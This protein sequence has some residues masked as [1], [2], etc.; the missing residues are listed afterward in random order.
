MDLL[1]IKYSHS[2]TPPAIL[3]ALWCLCCQQI[4][5][6]TRSCHNICRR[7]FPSLGLVTCHAKCHVLWRL[8]HAGRPRVR[9]G[10]APS[11]SEVSDLI[12]SPLLCCDRLYFLS[13]CLDTNYGNKHSPSLGAHKTLCHV[14]RVSPQQFS[15]LNQSE[16]MSENQRK[17]AIK[18]SYEELWSPLCPGHDIRA[19]AGSRWWGL[20]VNTVITTSHRGVTHSD[21]KHTASGERGERGE[22]T[23]GDITISIVCRPGIQGLQRRLWQA[24]PVR[25]YS[26]YAAF[27]SAAVTRGVTWQPCEQSGKGN[28]ILIL[29]SFLQNKSSLP[30][31]LNET[32]HS[33]FVFCQVISL[34]KTG[35]QSGWTIPDLS[36]LERNKS[37]TLLY[38]T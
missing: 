33:L 8:C 26:D 21:H 12:M 5:D 11:L 20:P 14:T 13:F 18:L 17:S 28:K 16:W 32:C 36:N 9:V 29:S 23:Q 2:H 34:L 10:D 38:F 22:T 31:H 30:L 4:S 3:S 35:T 37:T 19:M 27:C 15:C 24:R 25:Y 6:Q 1:N 7:L